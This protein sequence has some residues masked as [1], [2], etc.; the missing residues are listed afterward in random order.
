MNNFA[1]VPP[2]LRGPEALTGCEKV[3]SSS[4][5]A[6]R[7]LRIFRGPPMPPESPRCSPEVSTGPPK[8]PTGPSRFPKETHKLEITL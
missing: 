3:P 1:N 4:P 7:L 8:I 2:N 5:R 6:P